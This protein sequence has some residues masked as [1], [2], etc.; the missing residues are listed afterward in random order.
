MIHILE[1]KAT[2]DK[3]AL[4]LSS[5]Y[6]NVNSNEI[7][8]KVGIKGSSGF[9]GFGEKTP[10]VYY[11][12]PIENKTSINTIISGVTITILD[13]MGF[14]AK[15]VDIKKNDEDKT[16]VILKSQHSTGNIIGKDGRTLEALQ[17]L[18]NVIIEKKWGQ[19]P[20]I[21]LDISNYRE[22]HAKKLEELALSLAKKVIETGK[23]KLLHPMNPFE[24]RIIH[25]TLQ[26]HE[27]VTTESIGA[28]SHKKMKISL[29]NPP[30]NVVDNELL[31]DDESQKI[32]V[33]NS[34]NMDEEKNFNIEEETQDEEKN[35]NK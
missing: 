34:E 13:K 21:I 35:F 2:S 16:I 1:I 33:D 5:K 28:G 24:R 10:S 15:I 11:V 17:T 22:R 20:K 23:N 19:F 31:E 12:Y 9:L 32:L 26:D 7:Q 3:E 25:L 4:D 8:V 27:L 29:K 18:V 14:Q 30:A 6:L